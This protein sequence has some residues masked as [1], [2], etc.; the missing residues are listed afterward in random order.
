MSD[1]ENTIPPIT[2]KSKN[3]LWHIISTIIKSIIVLLIIGFIMLYISYWG[4]EV[5]T[6]NSSN[7]YY[8]GG[9]NYHEDLNPVYGLRGIIIYILTNCF[10]FLSYNYITNKFKNYK[11]AIGKIIF[12]LFSVFI[13]ILMLI[14]YSGLFGSYSFENT[15]L[16]LFKVII[17]SFGWITFPITFLII[18]L[19]FL[20]KKS[21]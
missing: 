16:E 5:Y 19:F 4:T 13:N 17:I 21:H 15:F 9:W 3:N 11:T 2:R 14:L 7:R 10:G 18:Y 1:N 8:T 12:I 6:K 20:F